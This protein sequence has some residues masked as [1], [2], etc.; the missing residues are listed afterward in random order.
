MKGVSFNLEEK[1]IKKL[2]DFK[3]KLNKKFKFRVTKKMIL[4]RLI[5]DTNAKQLEGLLNKK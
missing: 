1:T 3:K 5:S 2:N 4:E